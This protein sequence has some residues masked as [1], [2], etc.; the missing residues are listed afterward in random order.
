MLWVKYM[1]ED[2]LWRN[3]QAAMVPSYSRNIVTVTMSS[4]L[5]DQQSLKDE[6]ASLERRL[7]DVKAQLND[8]SVASIAPTATKDAGTLS[9]A[10][11]IYIALISSQH[12]M[13][14]FSSPT[15]LC[16]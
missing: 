5:V 13:H 10:H 4:P 6:I 12:S 15:R 14:C 8:D 7:R 2:Y 3:R 16:P 9:R 1:R 11:H